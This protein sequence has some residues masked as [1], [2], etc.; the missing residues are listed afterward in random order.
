[1]LCAWSVCVILDHSLF[2]DIPSLL[3]IQGT[4]P[5]AGL[6]LSLATPYQSFH[7]SPSLLFHRPW[8]SFLLCLPKLPWWFSLVSC[9]KGNVNS[10][11]NPSF[12]SPKISPEVYF[13]VL[14]ANFTLQ[15]Q[16]LTDISNLTRLERHWTP[17]L[18]HP[19]FPVSHLTA[20]LSSLFRPKSLESP[21]H[22]LSP[23]PRILLLPNIHMA[24]FTFLKSLL[25]WCH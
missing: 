19:S 1:M 22:R 21:L 10:K 9:F 24:N 2:C 18:I 8:S 17:D 16:C 15:F 25:K 12:C 20:N 13:L 14:T 5:P 7:A 4:I 3:G 23:L 6:P 11:K